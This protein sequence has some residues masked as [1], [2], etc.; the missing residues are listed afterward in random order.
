LNS[1][2]CLNVFLDGP[3]VIL[4]YLILISS[5]IMHYCNSV[6]DPVLKEAFYELVVIIIDSSIA[7]DHP[8][9]VKT[10]NHGVG[11]SVYLYTKFSIV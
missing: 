10:C 6:D 8:I 9:I 4:S 11:L 7:I 5:Q 2:T 1:E 3:Y